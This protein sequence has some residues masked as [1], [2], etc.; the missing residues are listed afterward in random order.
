PMCKQFITSETG[1]NIHHVL[2][3]HKGGSD[4]LE[5]LVL[6]HPNCHRQ[7]HVVDCSGQKLMERL[8]MCS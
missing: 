2:E 7:L 4:K 8:E 1:W 6:L 5:N 3:R